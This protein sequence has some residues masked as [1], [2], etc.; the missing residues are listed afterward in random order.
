MAKRS[1]RWNWKI[2]TQ[3]QNGYAKLKSLYFSLR[4]VW[5]II[6]AEQRTAIGPETGWE[7]SKLTMEIIYF[8]E[9]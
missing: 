2:K 5:D 8:E 9:D 1:E 4:A 6:A 7:T 3:V